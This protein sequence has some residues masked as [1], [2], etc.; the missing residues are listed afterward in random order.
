MSDKFNEFSSEAQ[1]RAEKIKAIRR[2]IHG[3]AEIAPTTYENKTETERT[4]S[5]SDRIMRAKEKKQS[6][7]A[8]ILD[9][10]DAAIAYEKALAAK[11]AE[12]A[13]RAAELYAANAS[14]DISDLIP[15]LETPAQEELKE[16]A[17]EIAGDFTDTVDDAVEFADIAEE[18]VEYADIPDEAVEY[19]D[20]PDE[21]VE[22]ADIPEKAVEYEDIP[23]NS[24]EPIVYGDES[25]DEVFSVKSDKEEVAKVLP[26]VALKAASEAEKIE[27]KEAPTEIFR[28][29]DEG[30]RSETS[31]AVYNN[32]EK[33]PVPA[34]KAVT[35]NFASEENKKRKKKKSLKQRFIN[36]F[37]HK[38]D[39]VGECIRKTVFLSSM[40]VIIVCGSF[41]L[42]YYYERWM[43]KKLNNE[44][45]EIYDSSENQEPKTKAEDTSEGDTRK[46]YTSML[47]GAKKLY[48]INNEIVGV[49]SI[50]DTP[51]NNP[52]LQAE[53]NDKYLRKKYDLTEN[54]AGEIFLDYRNHFDDVGEDGYL[55]EPNSGNLIIYGHNMYDDQMFGSLKYYIRNEAYYGQHPIINLSSNYEKYQYKIFAIFVLD[56]SDNTDT[57]FNCWNILDFADENAYYDFVNEA[58]RRSVFLN[59]VDVEYGDPLLTLS[60]CSTYFPDE[61]ARLII[62]ARMVR[63]GE[64]PL[65][66]TQHSWLNPNPKWPTIYYADYPNEHYDPD[67]EFIPYGPKGGK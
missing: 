10:L 49:I 48:D 67:A 64:D 50:P 45:M 53:D 6:T 37:P 16:I 7:V 8:D 14:P 25:L 29:P 42:N 33:S 65:K 32:E 39:S 15:E 57:E 66:G 44:I 60:T 13:K 35:E 18:S 24:A 19:A 34:M 54:D 51:V 62:L 2:S 30:K 41:I 61:R 38:G 27:N 5:I 3:E 36:L 20:I 52:V 26:G 9:E 1:R 17:E 59:D 11:Q 56:A 58:K 43:S 22:Y 47:D 46:R 55:K 63:E 21:A 28:V 4:E 31:G 40:A 23:E 12:E